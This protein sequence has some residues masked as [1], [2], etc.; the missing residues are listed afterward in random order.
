VAVI[1]ETEVERLLRGER[2]VDV[3]AERDPGGGFAETAV[4]GEGGDAV[5]DAGGSWLRLAHCMCM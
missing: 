4:S 3:L 5:E 1:F 2:D